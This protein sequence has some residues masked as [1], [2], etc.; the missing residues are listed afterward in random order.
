[1][2]LV[3]SR[4]IHV[5]VHRDPHLALC[6]ARCGV[7]VHLHCLKY[8][9]AR[10]CALLPLHSPKELCLEGLEDFCGLMAVRPLR[11]LK[12]CGRWRKRVRWGI[13]RGSCWG[14]FSSRVRVEVAVRLGVSRI[15]SPSLT[16]CQHPEGGAVRGTG[17]RILWPLSVVRGERRGPRR[18]RGSRRPRL[19]RGFRWRRPWVPSGARLWV[20]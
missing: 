10:L 1:V 4:I 7:T 19:L 6:H 16:S 9:P 18:R 12:P 3:L 5:C 20:K 17:L 13:P 14:S 15:M 8:E 11:R 2:D